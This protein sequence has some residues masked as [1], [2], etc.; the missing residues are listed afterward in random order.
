MGIEG[1]SCVAYDNYVY[2]TGGIPKSGNPGAS[3]SAAFYSGISPSGITGWAHTTPYLQNVT[4]SS[5]VAYAGYIY[6]VGGENTTG[7]PQNFTASAL[8][9]TSGISIWSSATPYP[10]DISGESCMAANNNIY[11]VGGTN[12][13]LGMATTADSYYAPITSPGVLGAWKATT[14]Y[15]IPITNSSCAP[16]GSGS[17]IC[18]GGQ[19]DTGITNRTYSAM[20]TLTGI[21]AWSRSP[22]YQTPLNETSGA[23]C[24]GYNRYTYCTAGASSQGTENY[25]YYLPPG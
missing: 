8:L 13:V 11:C 3:V 21:S 25:S 19:N 5:C 4:S 12:S 16:I 7:S 10:E 9:Q 23:S 14:S 24:V 22:D 2:C 15:P 1:Q 17:V 6:C 20:L 18:V